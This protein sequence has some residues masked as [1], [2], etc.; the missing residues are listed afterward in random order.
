MV[1]LSGEAEEKTASLTVALRPAG[2]VLH[3]SAVDTYIPSWRQLITD[4]VH[5][6]WILNEATYF[7][8]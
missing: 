5:I 7:L 3:Y 2:F 8:V 1:V 6:L 4:E